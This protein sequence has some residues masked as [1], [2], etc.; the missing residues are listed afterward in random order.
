MVLCWEMKVK[1]FVAEQF[2]HKDHKELKS[3]QWCHFELK[4]LNVSMYVSAIDV[5]IMKAIGIPFCEQLA[6]KCESMKTYKK[7]WWHVLLSKRLH[8]IG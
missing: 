2:T 1:E 8:G 5:F 6:A 4:I 7:I 3:V